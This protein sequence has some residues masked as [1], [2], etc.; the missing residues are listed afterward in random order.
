M[1]LFFIIANCAYA[2][3]RDMVLEGLDGDVTTNEYR[4]FIDK[5]NYLPPPP[6]SNIGNLMVD[7]KDG[8]RQHG[9]QTFY[10]FTH[11]RRVLDKAV[12]WSDA[13]LH[14]RNDPVTG[15]MQWTGKRELCWPNKDTNDTK[16]VLYSGTENGDVIEHIVNTARLILE[17]PA[18]WNETAPPDTFGFGA[19][20]LERAKT[21][22]RECQRSAETT[23]VP[24]YVHQTKDGYHLIHPDSKV[25]YKYCESSGPVPW[26]QQQSIVGG[27]LRLAQCHRLLN[28]G[29]TNIAYYEKITA[30]TARWFFATA[31]PVSAHN[32]V[33]YLWPYVAP[34]D[35]AT[36]PE[37][38][39]ESDYD[40]FI[41]RAYQANLGP[42]RQQMQRLINTGRFVMYLGTN[43]FA[44]KVNGTST[45]ERHERQFLNFEWIEMSVLE[46]EFYHLVAGSVLTSHEYWDNL[47]VEAAV[48]SAKHYW[49]TTTNPPPEII[50]DAKEIPPVPQVS[51][52]S[53]KQLKKWPPAG[54]LMLLW[55]ISELMLALFKR[56]KSNA[57]SKDR[58]SLKLIW[59][60][61]LAAIT[62]GI[63][64][65]YRLPAGR[66]H[67]GE[68][69]LAIGYC[70][71]VPGLVL[72]WWSI[73]YLGRFFTTNVAIA[74]D[75]QLIDSGPYR[76]IRHPSYTGSL[77]TLLGFTL[78]IP[79]WASWLLILVP[80]YA[81]TL[82]RIHVEE[83]ALLVGLGNAYRSYMQR[84][85]RLIPW[86]Y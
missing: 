4:S 56:S 16:Q 66:I 73:I 36:W 62:L 8:A 23:I 21:Y 2:G 67:P 85:K 58:H 5:L 82:W 53:S 41:F 44:G 15:R 46:R 86:I 18:V 71:F 49:A 28:D 22:V 77:L 42:T 17:N 37:V 29:N 61:K 11:D 27:L 9:L 45:P 33:C 57:V 31:L 6:T 72:R 69:G 63:I 40:M 13:F 79:N 24:W 48:L 7:E 68:I 50:E 55:G 39:T 76:L 52:F 60:V 38:I 74:N 81:I 80:C 34:R 30:D 35:P 12:E 51:G 78:C 65:A 59:L 70:L 3:D 75:H 83:A 84:T 25:Y 64:A 19:T 54:I 1:V 10:A 47:Q 14:A 43:R 32:R 20:Y 26:N